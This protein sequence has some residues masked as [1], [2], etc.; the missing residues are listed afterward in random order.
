MG[1]HVSHVWKT[2]NAG[3]SWTDFTGNLPDAPANTVLVDSSTATVYVGTDIGVFS[4]ST[5]NA[6]WTE[7]GPE[8]SSST[9]G[10]LPNVP[11][12]ALQMFDSGGTKKLRASNYGRGIWEFALVA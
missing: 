3:A 10:F 7:V 9:P 5:G 11:V 12:T 1:F 6:N 4:S 8:P 2:T